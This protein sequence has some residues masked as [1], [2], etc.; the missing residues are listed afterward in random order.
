VSEKLDVN[1]LATS[2]MTATIQCQLPGNGADVWKPFSF[3]ATYRVLDEQESDELDEK[4]LTIGDYLREVVISVEG[5][6]AGT[7]PKTGEE[8]SPLEC[9]IRNRFT[10]AAMWGDYTGRYGKNASDAVMRHQ[11]G[12][13]SR[14]SRKY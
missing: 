9:A 10:Q 4:G 2:T 14:R 11:S 5:V 13:N 1:L 12:K 7:D 8:V 3:K 6:P